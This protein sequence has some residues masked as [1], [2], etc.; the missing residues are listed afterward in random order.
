MRSIANFIVE[1]EPIGSGGMGKIL[2]GHDERGQLVAIKEILP[3]FASDFEIRRRIEQ[4][5]RILWELNH[6]SI[7][8]IFASFFDDKTQ[9]FYIVMELIDGMNIEQYI[10]QN[11][12][13]PYETAIEMMKNIL[14]ALQHVHDIGIIHRDLKPSNIMIRQNGDI[15]LLDFGVAKDLNHSGGTVFGDRIGTDGYMSPEQANGLSI[16][17]RSDIYSLGCVFFYMLTGH[18][19]YSTLA[20]EHETKDAIINQPFP[21]LSKYVSNIPSALQKCLDVATEKNMTKRYQSCSEFSS[22]L[23]NDTYISRHRSS[24]EEEIVLTIGRENCDFT[25]LDSQNKVS[26]H[27]ADLSCIEENGKRYFVFTDRSSNGTLFN[28]RMINNTSEKIPFD[29]EDPVIYLAG[30]DDAKLEWQEITTILKGRIKAIQP[31]PVAPV[32]NGKNKRRPSSSSWILKFFR[33]LSRK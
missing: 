9:N 19:A 23:K 1:D 14:D 22:A 33:V 29:A 17:R 28:N 26:R 4:E 32:T 24:K 30:V 18:H 8:K 15:C 12:P 20:S 3:E 31:D 11:G 7:V 6:K 10:R 13:I 5:I 25:V 21:K 16:D 27:H 2:R